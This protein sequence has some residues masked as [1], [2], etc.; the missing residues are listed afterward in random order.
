M[1]VESVHEDDAGGGGVSRGMHA[2]MSRGLRDSEYSLDL[3]VLRT[4]D[5]R[6]SEFGD[7]SGRIIVRARGPV[8]VAI[9]GT[10][11]GPSC[12]SG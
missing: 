12:G 7:D 8:A 6:K 2:T 5:R 3:W 1:A 11:T 10:G 9:A 4:I